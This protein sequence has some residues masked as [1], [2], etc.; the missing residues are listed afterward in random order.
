MTTTIATR[1]RNKL[2]DTAIIH[3]Y[4]AGASL[5]TV[6]AGFGLSHERVRLVLQRES[7]PIRGPG[8][9]RKAAAS[10]HPLDDNSKREQ[11]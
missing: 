5:R 7:V 6:A 8:D 9:W 3:A 4:L 10:C 1:G 2:R 11:K